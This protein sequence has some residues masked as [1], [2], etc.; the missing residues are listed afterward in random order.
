MLAYSMITCV[1]FL[2]DRPLPYQNML[3]TLNPKSGIIIFH[4]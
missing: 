1:Y 4:L 2:P 3:I